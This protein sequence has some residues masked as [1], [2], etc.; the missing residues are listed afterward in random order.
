MENKTKNLI[1]MGVGV[2]I[3]I[4]IVLFFGLSERKDKALNAEHL[5]YDFG[6]ISMGNGNVSHRF[7]LKNENSETITIKKIYTSCMCTTATLIDS[8]GEKRGT[9]GMPGHGDLS[10]IGFQIAGGETVEIEAIFD[11]AAHGP[12]GIGP[13][14]R[15]IYIETDLKSNPNF[16]LAIEAEVIN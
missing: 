5:L 2:L 4:A 15:I 10:N 8:K 13:V 12:E 6:V 7:A 1:L 14:K 3:L 9:F 11:P 16:Q